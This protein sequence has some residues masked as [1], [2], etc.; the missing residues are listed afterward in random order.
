[1]THR[2]VYVKQFVIHAC[3]ELTLFF[4][5]VGAQAGPLPTKGPEPP[6]YD[7][8]PPPSYSADPAAVHAHAKARSEAGGSAYTGP[9]EYASQVIRG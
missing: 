9:P 5:I 6:A 4:P 8:L 1:M 3:K 2:H 7:P